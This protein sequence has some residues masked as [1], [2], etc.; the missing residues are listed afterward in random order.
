MTKK[1]QYYVIGY[2][3]KHSL[4]PIIHQSF[5]KE[6]NQNINYDFLEVSP[7][8][9]ESTIKDLQK[10]NHVKGLSITVPFKERAFMLCNQF[11]SYAEITKAVSNITFNKKRELFGHNL[12]GYA[13]VLDLV[14]KKINL[15]NKNIL[16]L[17]AGGASRGLLLPFINEKPKSIYLL[18]RTKEKAEKI[19]YDFSKVFKINVLDINNNKMKFDI[20]INA[21]SASLSNQLPL[22]KE[23]FVMTKKTIGYDLSYLDNDTVFMAWMKAQSCDAYDG[24]GMLYELSKSIFSHWRGITPKSNPLL[25]TKPK[26]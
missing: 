5:A 13:L 25:N 2:P 7:S 1:D 22:V 10:M 6:T 20:I 18:N 26:I 23:D 16:I 17:G 4:S 19:A 3:V 9:F 15:T 8:E 14:Q 24:S 12:D 11:D 21:T